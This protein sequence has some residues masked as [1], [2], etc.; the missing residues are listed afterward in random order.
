MQACV[1]TF[2]LVVPV[3]ALV[4]EAT[5]SLWVALWRRLR[6]VAGLILRRL[7]RHA[8]GSPAVL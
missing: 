1:V 4:Y 7:R 3:S 2:A 8:G 6:G 5:H